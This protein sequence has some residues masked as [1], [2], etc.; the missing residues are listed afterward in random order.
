M[1]QG[2]MERSS[3]Q[4]QMP[5]LFPSEDEMISK[6]ASYEQNSDENNGPLF[7][8]NQKKTSFVDEDT[9]IMPVDSS[10]K[11]NIPVIESTS[12]SIQRI[13]VYYTDNTFQEFH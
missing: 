5:S 13:I 11:S 9:N 7:S 3:K 8:I 4:S 12:K 2:P 10:S 1:G 6:S